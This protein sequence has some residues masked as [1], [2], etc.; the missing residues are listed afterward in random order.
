V[1]PEEEKGR[2]AVE[3]ICRKGGFKPGM[4]E[5]VGDGIPNNSKYDCW[6]IDRIRFYS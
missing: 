4:K 1:N 6:Q 3:R 2:A 5:S